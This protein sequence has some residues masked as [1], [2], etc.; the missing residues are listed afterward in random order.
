MGIIVA[1]VIF[2]G[3]YKVGE[4]HSS[5]PAG[6]AMAGEYGQGGAAGTGAR[7]A[8]RA[9]GAGGFARNTANSTAGQIISED[10]DSI[11]VALPAGGSRIVFV[12]ST[13]PVMKSTA[14]SFS[15]LTTGENVIVSGTQNSDGSLTASSVQIRPAGMMGGMG[16]ASST[17]AMPGAAAAPVQ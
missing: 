5:T 9:G 6:G 4:S 10:A 15:D 11:T 16:G 1:I 12:S 7:G 2:F 14:G 3:G 8:G 17:A 13:T